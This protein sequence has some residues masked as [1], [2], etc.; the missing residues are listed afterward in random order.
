ML[1]PWPTGFLLSLAS[2]A[3]WAGEPVMALPPLTAL[4]LLTLLAS[5][6]V[7]LWQ[8]PGVLRSRYRKPMLLLALGSFAATLLWSSFTHTQQ[9]LSLLGFATILTAT[10]CT[11]NYWTRQAELHSMKRLLEEELARL[12]VHSHPSDLA[13]SNTV[14]AQATPDERTDAGLDQTRPRSSSRR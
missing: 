3:A 7:H 10:L 2:A 13:R 6:T 1:R 9:G 4:V 5:V 14:S 12:Q 11:L 8:C